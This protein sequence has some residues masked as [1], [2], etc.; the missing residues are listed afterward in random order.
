MHSYSLAGGDRLPTLGLGTWKSA[1]GAVYAAVKQA[2][3]LGYRH[4]DCAPIYQN[5]SEVGRAVAEAIASGQVSR[6]DLWLTSKLWN[7]AHA[8]D[9][10]QPALEKTLADLRVDAL[11]LFLIHWPVLFKP[12]V[13]FPRRAGDYIALDDLPISRTWQALE[14]CVA[15]GLVRHIGVSNFSLGKLDD[16]CRHAT[17]RPAMNQVELHP[18]LQQN[19]LLDFCR[20]NNI[21]VTAYSPLGSGDR[22]AGMKK[23]DEPSLLDNPVIGRVAAKHGITPAQTLLAWGLTRQTVVIPKSINPLRLKENL[24]A[25]DLRLDPDD[26]AEIA[27]LDLG[28]RFVDGA[29]FTGSGSPY[30]LASLW[31]A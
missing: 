16:L 21:L 25:A 29:F 30:T 23:R 14:A 9:Q 20:Q 18:Y 19:A 10:I 3:A 17:I 15:K 12:G 8:P 24:A 27:A 22:P 7:D 4:I 13:I 31:D 2:I 28:Y 5:E 26:M 11:D 1:P 6:G